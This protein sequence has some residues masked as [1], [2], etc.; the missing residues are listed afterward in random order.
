MELTLVRHT[1][2]NIAPGIC[3]GQSDILPAGTFGEEAKRTSRKIKDKQF[4]IVF[5]SPLKRCTLLAEACGFLTYTA[6]KRLAEYN[7]GDWELLPWDKITG[8]YAERWFKNYLELSAPNGE[9]LNEVIKRISNFLT[10]LSQMPVERVICFTHSGPI[11]IVHHLLNQLPVDQL[12]TFEV[13]YG[14]V[15]TFP[16]QQQE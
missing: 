9:S 7:F 2:L 6:D 5:S 14:G 10:E 13:D 4:D 11:R 16:V 15:Y 8:Q 1:R 3:Y 12:F